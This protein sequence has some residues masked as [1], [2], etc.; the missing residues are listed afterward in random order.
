[1][2]SVRANLT[3]ITS[4]SPLRKIKTQSG[5]ALAYDVAGFQDGITEEMGFTVAFMKGK[6]CLYML[7]T[8]TFQSSKSRYQEDMNNII[9][10]FNELSGA[11]D[12]FP[13][14]FQTDKYRVAMPDGFSPD[15]S[16]CSLNCRGYSRA[17][18]NIDVTITEVEQASWK[19]AYKSWPDRK[20]YS[21]LEYFAMEQRNYQV[22]IS[23]QGTTH[24]EIQQGK[25]SGASFCSFTR[26]EPAAEENVGW[27]YRYTIVQGKTHFFGINIFCPTDDLPGNQA[28]IKAVI[29]SFTLL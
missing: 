29:D 19:T 14:E 18:G 1:M 21:L 6:S 10:S 24:D 26:T 9:S 17:E 4:E 11:I 27:Y 16:A 7:M 12:T 13:H 2:E 25:I 8:W 20:N 28:T 3:K 23:P 22:R 5:E 15:T